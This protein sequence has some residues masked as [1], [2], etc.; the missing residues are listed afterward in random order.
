MLYI[1]LVYIILVCYIYI[2]YLHLPRDHSGISELE[3]FWGFDQHIIYYVY[4]MF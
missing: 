3:T 4:M 2:T 1:L